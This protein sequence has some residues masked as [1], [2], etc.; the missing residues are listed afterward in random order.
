[1]K[2]T[3]IGAM[4]FCATCLAAPPQ[5]GEPPSGGPGQG[6]IQRGPRNGVGR[7]GGTQPA[8][9]RAG[10]RVRRAEAGEEL[11]SSESKLIE[12]LEEADSME[13]LN[14]LSRS[15]AASRRAEVRQAMVDALE[16][17]GER[18]A[19]SLAVYIAD[20]DEDVAE[21]AFSAWTSLLNDMSY[22]KRAQA[23]RSAAAALGSAGVMQGGGYQ[24]GQGGMH[25][26]QGMHPGQYPQGQYPQGQ[27]PQGQ[28]QQGQYPQGQHPGQFQ[29][30]VQ[31][32]QH[33][34]GGERRNAY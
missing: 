20:S 2:I 17:Q 13:T 27:Y 29:Q 26:T 14:R 33:P 3:M 32:G 34:Q 7:R 28:Y 10:G 24:H 5:G 15:A 23:I 9:D 6:Q 18:A 22:R 11:S 1:M 4:V 12:Q 25:R 31:P 8:Q 30:G 16:R 21:S 19:D